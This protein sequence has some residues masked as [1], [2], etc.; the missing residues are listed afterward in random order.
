MDYGDDPQAAP[1]TPGPGRWRSASGVTHALV[2]LAVG[3]LGWVALVVVW[4][5]T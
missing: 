3:L 5:M 2:A 4:A 1:S